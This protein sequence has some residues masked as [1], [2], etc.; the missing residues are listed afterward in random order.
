MTLIIYLVMYH[1]VEFPDVRTRVCEQ[2]HVLGDLSDLLV[3]VP[4]RVVDPLRH[5]PAEPHHLLPHVL[6]LIRLGNE[7]EKEKETGILLL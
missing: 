4:G 2:F 7:T 1:H 6:E 3:V 5:L